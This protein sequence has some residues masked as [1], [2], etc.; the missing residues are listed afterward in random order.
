MPALALLAA[1]ALAAPSAAARE[2]N[3]VVLMVGGDR[4]ACEIIELEAANLSLR[5]PAFGTV[6]VDWP[7]VTGCS[8]SSSSR[9]GVPTGR[10]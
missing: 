1:G 8:A 4:I 2:R 5:T 3:D 7:D 10:G 9:S 6:N